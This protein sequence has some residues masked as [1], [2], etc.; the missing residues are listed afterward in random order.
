MVEVWVVSV[1]T[2]RAGYVSAL[3]RG[4]RLSKTE[5]VSLC[6]DAEAPIRMVE[7]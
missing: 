4:L 6:E 7:I 2:C 5:T 3:S 1:E